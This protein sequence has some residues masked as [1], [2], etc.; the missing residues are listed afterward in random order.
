MNKEIRIR[1]IDHINV[2]TGAVSNVFWRV[3]P[4]P[5]YYFNPSMDL[6][7]PNPPV[8]VEAGLQSLNPPYSY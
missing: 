6:Q 4:V 2:D 5:Q 7:N 8:V 1:I 3:S